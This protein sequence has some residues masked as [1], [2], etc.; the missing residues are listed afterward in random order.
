[1]AQLLRALVKHDPVLIEVFSLTDEGLVA[2][3]KRLCRVDAARGSRRKRLHAL[4]AHTAVLGQSAVVKLGEFA[5]FVTHA[6][7]G[8]AGLVGILHNV[9]LE[10]FVHSE[11]SV[12]LR[13]R[14]CRLLI[15]Q[16]L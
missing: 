11:F 10:F 12:P 1:M 4:G 13:H 6:R 5:F 7:Q 8:Q 9:L 15:L 3:A 2:L 14:V 16:P